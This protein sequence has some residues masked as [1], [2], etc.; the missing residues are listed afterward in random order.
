STGK[1][2]RMIKHIAVALSLAL[3]LALGVT[4]WAGDNTTTAAP[5]AT[6]GDAA[7]ANTRP[8]SKP[9][10]AKDAAEP[11]LL[12]RAQ[13]AAD[14][15]AD[16]AV[17]MGKKAWDATADTAARAGDKAVGVGKK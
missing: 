5:G 7:A 16:A 2:I 17:D 13:K 15:T 3:A 14:N 8:D 6:H 10:P 11:N 9:A 1:D 4:A 12:D